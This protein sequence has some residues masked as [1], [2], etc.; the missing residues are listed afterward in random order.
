ML[1][2]ALT[3]ER[4]DAEDVP[5]AQGASP[6]GTDAAA[7]HFD[8]VTTRAAFDALEDDWNDLF[9]RAG[10]DTQLFQTFNWLWHWANHYLPPTDDA[11]G[12][13]LA[14]VTARIGGRLALAWPMVSERVGPITQLS[15]MG[16]PV[17]QYGDVVIDPDVDAPALLRAALALV[18]ARSGADVLRLRKVREDSAIAP[19]LAEIDARILSE[20]TAP[21]LT[22]SGVSD[23][24]Y[25][26]RLSSGARRKRRQK[27]RKLEEQSAV[28]FVRAT[29][30][31]EAQA[32]IETTFRLKRAWLKSRGLLSAAFSDPRMQ[33]LFIALASDT[34]RPA[35]FHIQAVTC[36]GQPV[37]IETGF[38]CKGRCAPH[39]SAYEP[40]FERYSVGQLLWEDSIRHARA[41]GV[42]IFDFMAPGD[43]Y[44]LEW[45]DNTV[46]VRDWA[47]PT[48]LAGRAYSVIGL[49]LLRT[50]AKRGLDRMPV[51]AR[52]RIAETVGRV[53]GRKE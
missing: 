24:D 9:A 48:S 43:S 8:L 5:Q 35:G 47:V 40:A 42:A 17:S 11:G 22:L 19:F 28:G 30:G 10:R 6:A 27:R 41:D 33:Q 7:A 18:R 31:A 3:L 2:P 38:I 1:A 46:A 44:K 39:I 34:S 20:D 23:A 12:A 52:R 15:W 45:A 13:K 21:Y 36:G 16:A 4:P 51:G 53:L 25:E 14:I 32:L 29:A 37:A 50:A 26:K 49:G